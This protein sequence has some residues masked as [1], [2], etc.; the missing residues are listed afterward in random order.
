MILMNPQ[1]HGDGLRRHE[2]DRHA[3]MLSTGLI[4]RLW[5]RVLRRQSRLKATGS[6]S[7]T[8][9]FQPYQ[10][11]CENIVADIAAI[12]GARIPAGVSL[13]SIKLYETA[14]AFA[15]WHASDNL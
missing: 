6:I 9:L 4:M 1:R 12:L 14:T 5:Y 3:R 7:A 8:S 10:P 2:E 15:E 11:T 13:H